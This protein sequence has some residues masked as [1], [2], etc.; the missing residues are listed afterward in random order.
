MNLM[1]KID[2]IQL[3]HGQICC[4]QTLIRF[5]NSASAICIGLH[6]I[7]IMSCDVVCIAYVVQHIF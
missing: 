6:T 3:N 4:G 5:F 1:K 2:Q 7:P